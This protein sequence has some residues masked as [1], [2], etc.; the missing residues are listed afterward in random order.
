MG[1]WVAGVAVVV[2]TSLLIFGWP[3]SS[4]EVRVYSLHCS[5]GFDTAGRC[6]SELTAWV[7]V[8]YRVNPARGE[9]VAK[10]GSG[11]LLTS[12]NCSIFD[13]NNWICP[14]GLSMSD[15]RLMEPWETP[16]V[17]YV[18]RSCYLYARLGTSN[19]AS[20]CLTASRN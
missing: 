18:P 15:G 5:G 11:N 16:Y 17:R 9:V 8:T 19:S 20:T 12:S 3:T 4:E 6:S 7:P 10:T 2:A 1:F 14:N 13:R